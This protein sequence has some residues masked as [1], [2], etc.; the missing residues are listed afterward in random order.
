[1]R[2]P[3]VALVVATSLA[4]CTQ[5]PEVGPYPCELEPT[6]VSETFA[7]GQGEPVGNGNAGWWSWRLEVGD[8][9]PPSLLA[10]WVDVVA[11]AAALERCKGD[12]LALMMTMD[13]SSS[14]H[15]PTYQNS[16]APRFDA[17]NGTYH[18]ESALRD[19]W[20]GPA[21]AGAEPMAVVLEVQVA[22]TDSGLD[23]DTACVEALVDT[24]TLSLDYLPFKG[25]SDA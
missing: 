7:V 17:A 24:A 11:Q 9:C 6:A 1:M 10:G 13:S 23:D 22:H 5:V 2:V 14:G 3:W 12:Q 8:A 15:D 18:Y 16:A 20:Y 25:S 4:G 21:G 19:I